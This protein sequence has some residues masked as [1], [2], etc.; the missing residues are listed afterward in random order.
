LIE[1]DGWWR[2]HGVTA[3]ATIVE[4]GMPRRLDD[5]VFD[6]K[7]TADVTNPE[8]GEVVR[9]ESKLMT[10]GAGYSAGELVRVRWSPKRDYFRDY[11]SHTVPEEEWLR[12]KNTPGAAFTLGGAVPAAAAGGVQIVNASGA[13]PAT[14]LAKL[15]TLKEQGLLS[16]EQLEQATS[17]L[18]GQAAPTVAPAAT[19]GATVEERLKRLQHLH[20]SGTINDGEFADERRRILDSL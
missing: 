7:V 19:P 17:Q 15:A 3:N 16:Q 11:N 13:D 9:M 6:Q 20:D 12:E 18:Q 14:V 4:V 8:T 2:K 5:M 1:G 10:G